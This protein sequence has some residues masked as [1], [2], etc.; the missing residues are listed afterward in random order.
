[1]KLRNFCAKVDFDAEC[2]TSPLQ[3]LEQTKAGDTGEAVAMNRNLFAAMNYIDIVP[4]FK[5]PGDFRVR[6]FVGRAQIAQRPSGKNHAPT[7]RVIRP[8]T[9]VDCDVMRGIGLLH[10][11][12]KIHS[13]RAA[14]DDFDFHERSSFNAAPNL[15]T[16]VLNNSGSAHMPT[17]KCCGDSKKRPGTTAE[18]YFS[19]ST[20]Q[21]SSTRPFI[22][23]V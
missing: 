18:S 3:N 16:P 8:V 14:A 20:A 23:R 12:G 13:G 7:E 2:F 11:D 5:V 4:G 6:R 21:R 9:F 17:R 19:V 22:S 10:Q 1:M 15:S